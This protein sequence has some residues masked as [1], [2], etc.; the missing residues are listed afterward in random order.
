MS[1]LVPT[2]TSTIKIQVE[3]NQCDVPG[4]LQFYAYPSE[5][6][7]DIFQ[8][9]NRDIGTTFG[10][11]DLQSFQIG[12]YDEMLMTTRR[13]PDERTNFWMKGT[14]TLLKSLAKAYVD[15]MKSGDASWFRIEQCFG[16]HT[17]TVDPHSDR[18][19]LF[20]L[21]K[22][23]DRKLDIS[24]RGVENTFKTELLDEIKEL[25]KIEMKMNDVDMTKTYFQSKRGTFQTTVIT[26][27]VRTTPVGRGHPLDGY[28]AA[29]ENFRN[30]RR[31]LRKL[32]HS[33]S[34]TPV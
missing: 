28:C 23:L 24:S 17:L 3:I 12:T 33:F 20:S 21:F 18:L 1:A 11:F 13:G 34:V 9:V 32:T 10:R 25:E 27:A 29:D 7:K 2:I 15:W 5:T 22:Q 30:W 14:R 26:G 8:R 6:I 19:V 31:K 16:T 4:F